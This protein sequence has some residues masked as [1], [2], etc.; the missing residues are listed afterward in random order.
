M[1]AALVLVTAALAAAAVVLLLV[2]LREVRSDAL[3]ILHVDDL[4]LLRKEQRRRAQGEGPLARIAR[5]QVP[6]LRRVLGARRVEGLQRRIDEAG[7]PGGLTVD[8]FLQECATWGLIISPLVLLFVLQ[9]SFLY[10]PLCLAVPVLLPM[11]RVAGA[12]RKRREQMDRDLPDFL[13]VLAVTVMA[14]VNFRA[15]LARVSSRFEGPLADEVMLTLHQ[16]AN[17][18]SVRDAFDDMRRRS[19]SE[20]VAQFVSALLQSQELGAPL[21]ESLRQIADDVRRASA[22]RQRQAAA[23]TAP[24]V[25]LVTSVVLLPA[26]MILI[27]VGLVLGMDVDF[28]SLLGSI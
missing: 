26:A 22:Q 21:A 24:R 1:T 12:Q 3:D 15:A 13:D 10:V 14:G 16:I 4:E 23:K 11:G 6:R 19:S 5:G 2:G 25:T 20:S 27:V 17:G 8:G 28:G 7:R 18:A 9:G